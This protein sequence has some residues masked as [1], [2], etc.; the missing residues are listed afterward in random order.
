MLDKLKIC[1]CGKSNA[2]YEQIS[3]GIK[4]EQCYGCGFVSND[5][6][7][8]GRKFL[9]EQV[10]ILP[11]IYKES[12]FDDP[13][14]KGKKW[15]PSMIK[16]EDKGMVFLNGSNKDNV[17]WSA[18]LSKEVTEEEKTKYPIPDKPGHFYKYRMDVQTLK[19]FDKYDY[20]GALEYIGV[21][22]KDVEE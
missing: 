16:L 18:I 21:L 15:M 7:R 3:S 2:C 9:K 10:E 22:P 6:M 12:L 20:I 1:P 11:E 8:E 4:W 19:D 14:V 5:L 17:K 13:K